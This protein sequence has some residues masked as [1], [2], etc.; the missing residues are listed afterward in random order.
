MRRAPALREAVLGRLRALGQHA[1]PPDGVPCDAW[2]KHLASL[3]AA[4]IIRRFVW[5][6][7]GE[8][9]EAKLVSDLWPTHMKP[10][11]LYV[12]GPRW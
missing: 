9:F 3:C 4:G 1:G 12:A 7:D 5:E 11:P 2:K 6:I 8:K 10:P